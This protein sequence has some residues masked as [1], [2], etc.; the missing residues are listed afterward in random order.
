[1]EFRHITTKDLWRDFTSLTSIEQ[2][3]LPISQHLAKILDGG[4]PV[5]DFSFVADSH[6]FSVAFHPNVSSSKAKPPKTDE[7]TGVLISHSN[8]IRRLFHPM[9]PFIV[10]TADPYINEQDSL[11]RSLL[12]ILGPT[13]HDVQFPYPVFW[14]FCPRENFKYEGV[15]SSS[16]EC[17]HFGSHTRWGNWP[18]IDTFEAIEKT[19]RRQFRDIR[20]AVFSACCRFSCAAGIFALHKEACDCLS[21]ELMHSP[22]HSLDLEFRWNSVPTTNGFSFKTSSSATITIAL[23]GE[24]WLQSNILPLLQR[25]SSDEKGELMINRP[26]SSGC[27]GEVKRLFEPRQ[28]RVSSKPRFLKSAPLDSLLA[29]FAA[30]VCQRREIHMFTEM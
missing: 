12:S 1:M 17:V 7:R 25:A 27:I 21:W 22:L 3:I 8:T 19:F 15:F 26:T 28:I 16:R 4:R 10:I 5:D 13:V 9:T 20:S 23:R 2:Y 6:R 24:D 18:E 11:R 30:A 14:N 29:M